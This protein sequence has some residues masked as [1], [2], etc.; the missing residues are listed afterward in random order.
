MNATNAAYGLEQK[1][2]AEGLAAMGLTP[3]IDA[4]SQSHSVLAEKVA[5]ADQNVAAIEQQLAV[6]RVEA[7]LIKPP[8]DAAGESFAKAGADSIVA[9]PKVHQLEQALKDAREEADNAKRAMDTAGTA[10][11]TT[12]AAA[13]AAVP[14]IQAPVGAFNAAANAAGN[15]THN[16][17][18]ARSA[19]IDWNNTTPNTSPGPSER[20]NY[21][22]GSS[23]KDIEERLITRYHSGGTVEFPGG[24]SEGLAILQRD[25]E[26]LP[27]GEARAY[28]SGVSESSASAGSSRFD[29]VIQTLIDKLDRIGQ[30]SGDIH[31]HG[32]VNLS[33]DYPIDRLLSDIRK[34][35]AR[36]NLARGNIIGGY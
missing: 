12:G 7:E 30:G 18:W 3:T 1:I 8:M 26:V 27:P 29:A 19:L 24:A 22:V 35:F 14:A 21:V 16:A 6:A 34:D 32:N 13:I 9:S 5:A 28:R 11:T 4:A 2:I 17:E 36:A 33:A 20:K 25:E 31:F 10:A 15:F 23:V